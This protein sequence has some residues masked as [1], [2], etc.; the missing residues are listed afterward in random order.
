[1]LLT[2]S[3]GHHLQIRRD[4]LDLF[5]PFFHT[6][7]TNL[8]N[9]KKEF[10][11]PI[12]LSALWDEHFWDPSLFLSLNSKNCIH[13]F[14]PTE[15]TEI[16]LIPTNPSQ[17]LVAYNPK[18]QKS[19]ISQS[20]EQIGSHPFSKNLRISRIELL[21]QYQI[22]SL[23]SPRV[24]LVKEKAWPKRSTGQHERKRRERER[25]AFNLKKKREKCL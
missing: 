16:D 24:S 7:I 15:L 5:L 21:R 9:S 25:S 23:P 13:L 6:W 8:H 20:K 4:R 10:H 22:F 18:N 17:S 14:L 2:Q 11:V 12:N 1:M 19:D 3:I